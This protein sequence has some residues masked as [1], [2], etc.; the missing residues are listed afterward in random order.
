MKKIVLSTL[1]A[2]SIA[3]VASADAQFYTDS[4][5]QVFTKGGEGRTAIE[6]PKATSLF[7]KSGKLDFSMLAYVGYQNTDYRTHNST[8]PDE[9][10]FELRRMYF[11]VKA[12][13]LENPKDYFRITLDT[14]S[15]DGDKTMRIKY[16]Y[17]YLD[18]ILPNTGVEI[19]QSHTTWLD[20]AEG[21]SWH[22]R[23][24]LETFAEQG[25]GAHLD[26]SADLG[27]DFKTN[28]K[29]V[30]TEIGVYNGE[31][32]HAAQGSND[33]TYYAA[34]KGMDYEARLTFHVL[35]NNTKDTK[36][37]YW[38]ASL[39][40]K[41]NTK[42][43]SDGNDLDYIGVHTVFNTEPLL[44][45]AQYIQSNDTASGSAVSVYAGDGYSVNFDAR[46]GERNQYHVF[47]RYDKWTPK[48]VSGTT[49][50]ANRTYIGGAAWDM[51]K[52]IQWVA[53][54]ITKDNE[55]G[56]GSNASVNG[57]EYM[58]TAQIAF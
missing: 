10:Q 45:A 39:Y 41:H 36:K 14:T 34:K 38:D 37:T 27:V 19:G 54:V 7:T 25:N 21:H 11:Q 40:G 49:E 16:A 26:S 1:A 46:M 2:L 42:H 32:Y 12:H 24:I 58:L 3:T 30:S 48:E 6:M 53:N 52:N 55:S 20:Y 15:R 44:V 51:N 56:T 23:N 31:G 5:G 29:Y 4:N 43:G 9:S 28:T 8:K 33:S 35:G 18:K 17:L 47:G 57:N 22:Y 13:L 50:Y